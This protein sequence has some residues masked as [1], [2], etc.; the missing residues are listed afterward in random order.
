MVVDRIGGRMKRRLH[1]EHFRVPRCV[2]PTPL[3]SGM[4]VETRV[5]WLLRR[6]LKLKSYL[7]LSGY[8]I[9]ISRIGWRICADVVTPTDCR[10]HELT[11]R[12]ITV[13]YRRRCQLR[14]GGRS[15]STQKG[16]PTPRVEMQ[17]PASSQR[18]TRRREQLWN[19]CQVL[20]ICNIRI[21]SRGSIERRR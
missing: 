2:F 20:Y 14:M 18:L 7:Y 13:S 17:I 19:T 3:G 10:R 21:D 12:E 9:F 11:S 6:L 8:A 16:R 5:G 15:P 1:P 4:R